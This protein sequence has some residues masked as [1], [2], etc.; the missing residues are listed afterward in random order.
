[1]FEED[2]RRLAA[3]VAPSVAKTS[4]S[5]HFQ[6]EQAQNPKRNLERS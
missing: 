3:I 6:S 4:S 2:R 5:V 1:V